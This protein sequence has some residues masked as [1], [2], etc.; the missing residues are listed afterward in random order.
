MCQYIT[1][2]IEIS[3]LLK[4]STRHKRSWTRRLV[5]QAQNWTFVKADC[6]SP[7]LRWKDRDLRLP[8]PM[9]DEVP[10]DCVPEGLHGHWVVDLVSLFGGC[11]FHIWI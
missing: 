10:D 3:C 4:S 1:S 8:P 2:N 11:Y 6:V 7:F 9:L 5:L